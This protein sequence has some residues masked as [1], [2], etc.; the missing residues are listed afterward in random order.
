MRLEHKDI[1]K[2]YEETKEAYL[3]VL[4]EH[5][6]ALTDYEVAKK[7]KKRVEEELEKIL[8]VYGEVTQEIS[9][10]LETI[11]QLAKLTKEFP[12]EESKKSK[13]MT[14]KKDQFVKEWTELYTE[15]LAAKEKIEK[16]IDT[17]QLALDKFN[18]SNSQAE[19]SPKEALASPYSK[20]SLRIYFE[21]ISSWYTQALKV[22]DNN[23]VIM[24]IHQELSEKAEELN[25]LMVTKVDITQRESLETVNALKEVST[26][27]EKL[28]KEYKNKPFYTIPQEEVNSIIKQFEE[29]EVDVEREFYRLTQDTSSLENNLEELRS[30][31]DV[32]NRQLDRLKEID[33]TFP[34]EHLDLENGYR[35]VE[36][37]Y[38]DLNE[39]LTDYIMP[40]TG[41]N[42]SFD[43]QIRKNTVNNMEVY[44]N[45]KEAASEIGMEK[46]LEKH[47]RAME[48][49][50]LPGRA[51]TNFNDIIYQEYMFKTKTFFNVS[52]SDMDAYF[53]EDDLEIPDVVYQNIEGLNGIKLEVQQPIGKE[54][55]LPELP[56]LPPEIVEP[57]PV[58]EIT[59]EV[60]PVS[61]SDKPVEPSYSDSLIAPEEIIAPELAEKVDQEKQ[62]IV[63]PEEVSDVVYSRD[64]TK[65]EWKLDELVELVSPQKP[66]EIDRGEQVISPN[67]LPNQPVEIQ[68][69][70][71]LIDPKEI[72]KNQDDI[73]VPENIIYPI[74]IGGVEGITKPVK[75]EELTAIERVPEPEKPKQKESPETPV[76]PEVP[77][78]SE[79]PE[80]PGEPNKPEISENPEEKSKPEIQEK[81][82][83]IEKEKRNSNPTISKNPQVNNLHDVKT[84]TANQLPQTGEKSFVVEILSGTLAM[85]SSAWIFRRKK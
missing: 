11:N 16:S 21:E 5:N 48:T 49:K 60:M 81:P 50:G 52:I 22:Y 83:E 38:R 46:F 63:K 44:H 68:L 69:P 40:D 78:E 42:N 80:K 79:E 39:Y 62:E 77:G 67:E 12:V 57:Q 33:E 26:R 15:S 17:Y 59:I 28:Y 1:K 19:N 43:V 23:K 30:Q 85:I 61:L 65:N 7:E 84:S 3:E 34:M 13:D 58:K 20:D 75:P 27:P 24:E 82:K 55:I 70:K 32:F 31:V 73:K 9:S 54:V 14:L 36:N 45:V 64:I 25:Q 74:E 53:D 56:I 71:Q 6:Q 66:V 72:D 29:H 47:K 51:P 2:M 8:E 35:A 4:T 41:G 76:K 37:T 18:E 10:Q